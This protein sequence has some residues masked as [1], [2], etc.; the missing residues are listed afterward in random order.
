MPLYLYKCSVCKE[1]FEELRPVEGRYHAQC[2]V[3]KSED[4]KLLVPKGVNS[5]FE[6]KPQYFEHLDTKPVFI[7]S[8]AHLREECKKRGVWAKCLD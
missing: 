6:L 5:G 4:C 8:K 7:E 1:E 2:P 3:C